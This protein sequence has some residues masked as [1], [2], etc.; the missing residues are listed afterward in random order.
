MM[1]IKY[2]K[3]NNC[4]LKYSSVKWCTQKIHVVS[5]DPGWWAMILTAQWTTWNLNC[6]SHNAAVSLTKK[7]TLLM[8]YK[9]G[10]VKY[11]KINLFFVFRH[12]YVH[13]YTSHSTKHKVMIIFC[14]YIFFLRKKNN[15]YEDTKMLIVIATAF[16]LFWHNYNFVY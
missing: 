13:L 12:L 4:C 16:N 9:A 11:S 7:L 8:I 14:T 5:C 15:V 6:S 2:Y 3:L 1:N 10:V